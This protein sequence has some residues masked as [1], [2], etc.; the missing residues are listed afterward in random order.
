MKPTF[1]QQRGVAL[2]ISIVV[3]SVLLLVA[4]AISNVT[5]K[6]ITLANVNKDSHLAFYAA[7]SGAE[8]ALYWDVKAPSGSAFSTSSPYT[9]NC[10]RDASNPT[11]QWTVGGGGDTQATS[12]FTMY[13]LPDPQCAIVSVHKRY[14]GTVLKTRIESRGYNSCSASNQR[15][16][17]RAVRAEY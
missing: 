7:D 1:F 14:E 4:F 17:E 11:N 5:L 15:R 13:F 10:N 12:T 2:Y 6:Q 8:C 3:T 16:V 9:I